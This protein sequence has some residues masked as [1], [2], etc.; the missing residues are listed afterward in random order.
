MNC[1]RCGDIM[2]LKKIFDYGGYSWSWKCTHCGA[3]TD[4]MPIGDPRVKGEAKEGNRITGR[5]PTT[6]MA[7]AFVRV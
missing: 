4:K 1:C 6:I 2:I 7:V 3:I 5:E